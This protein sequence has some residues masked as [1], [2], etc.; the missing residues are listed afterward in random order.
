MLVFRRN[1]PF[2]IYSYRVKDSVLIGLEKYNKRP[3]VKLNNPTYNSMCIS[4]TTLAIS[5]DSSGESLHKRGYRVSQTDAHKRVLAAGMLLL[6]G[7]DG[8]LQFIVPFCSSGTFL[9]EAALVPQIF[10]RDISFVFWFE[11]WKDFIG[12]FDVLYQDEVEKNF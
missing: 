6:A 4:L 5:L 8:R 10:L 2:Q 3:S 7:W 1:H 12:S 9:I 11:K